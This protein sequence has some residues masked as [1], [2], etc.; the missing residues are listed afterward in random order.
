MQHTGMFI[1]CR[2]ADH[3]QGCLWDAAA[4][5]D[6]GNAQGCL[7]D[8]GIEQHTGIWQYTGM[9]MECRDAAHRDA[10]STQGCLWDAGMQQLTGMLAMP[11]V[12]YGMQGCSSQGCW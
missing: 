1:R 10:G 2:D 5:R 9:F 3:A 4:H 8:A 7:W 12:V 11:R 6:A